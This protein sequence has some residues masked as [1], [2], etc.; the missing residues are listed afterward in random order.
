MLRGG[1]FTQI[2]VE[3]CEDGE[4]LDPVRKANIKGTLVGVEA[5]TQEGLKAMA[6]NSFAKKLFR[7]LA[8]V[9]PQCGM[10]SQAVAFNMF[11]AFFRVCWLCSA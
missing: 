3:A 7:T 8:R 10:V 5:V 2:T 6:L 4:Y 11:L 1:C 9:I